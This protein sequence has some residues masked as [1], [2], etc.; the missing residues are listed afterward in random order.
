MCAK[1]T[2]RVLS[3]MQ[4][5]QVDDMITEYHLNMLQTDKGILLFE[6]ELE[7]LRRASK[8]VVDVTLPPGPTVSEIKE[9]V[10]KFNIELKQSDDGPQ[11]HGT[12]YDIND[13]VNYLVDLMKE[14]LDF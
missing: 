9:T 5:K 10:D 1:H 6:G 13:A 12:L 2:M 8:H 14:R 7:D 4:P 11:F 3:G